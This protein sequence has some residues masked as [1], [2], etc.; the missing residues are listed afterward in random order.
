VL[1]VEVL[2]RL[3]GVATRA[4]LI[5][6]S[7]RAEVDRALADGAVVAPARGRY[8]LPV[9]DEARAAAHRLSGVVSHRSAALWWGWSVRSEPPEP[10]VILPKN[11]KV[12]PEQRRGVAV[13]RA[14]L[15]PDDVTDGVTSKDRTL[16][17]C[18]RSLPFPEGLSIADSALRSGFPPARLR[19]LARDAAG[20]GGHTARRVAAEASGLA[21]NPFES[22]LRAIA[23][24]VPGLSVRAQVGIRDPGFLGRPDLVDERLRIILEADSFEWHGGRADLAKDARRYNA[25]VV[26]GWLVLRFSWED[27][28]L[29]PQL[30][31]RI[32]IAAVAE[33]TE[34]LCPRC[35]AA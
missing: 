31:E 28:M 18:V 8:A 20:P 7:S 4:Q 13:H 32:L 12:T 14:L 27:V 15:G 6:M 26:H 34:Q 24:G 33:R 25:F 5:E 21:A 11:R 23:V 35:R 9:V 16:L 10:D 1:V 3:G 30:V 22:C 17:D 2:L 29:H 19:A